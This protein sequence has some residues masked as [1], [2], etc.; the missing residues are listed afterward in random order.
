MIQW[1][2]H[3]YYPIPS[4]K[5]AEMMGA[6]KLMEFHATREESIYAEKTDPFHN[7]YE[8][9]HWKMADE[10]FS[11][12]DELV[13]LGG[14]RSGKSEFASKRVVKCTN[15]IPEANVLCMHTTSATSIEQQQ[16]YVYKYLPAEWKQAK[17]GK[18]T[19]MT[20]SKKGGFTESCCVTPNGSRIFFRNYSQNLDTGILEGSEWD[21]VW[22]DELCG[23]DHISALRFRLVTRANRPAPNYPNGYPWR[24]ML[25]TFTPVAGYTPTIREYLQGAKTEKWGMADPE[26]L[27]N[28]RVPIIQQPLR[29]NAKVI[30][31]HSVWN[32]FNDYRALKRTLQNDP[33]P[34]ILTRA[35]GLP[36]K[37]SGSMFPK[38]CTDHLVNDE[39]IPKD[40]TNYMVV[41]PS[42]GKNWV[43]IWVRVAKDGK[44]YVYR[45]FP[46]QVNPIEGVGMAGEWAVAGKKID[47]VKGH[48]QESWGWSLARYKEEILRQ[49]GNEK[50]FMRIMDSRFGSA[51]TPTKSG[52][53]TLIDEMAD[54]DMFFEPSVGV[55]IEEGITLVNSLLDFNSEQPISS[56]NC[57]KLYVHEDCKNLRFALSTWTNSDGKHA[58]T[59]DFCDLVRY[60]VLSAP[61]FLD[62]GSGTI[63]EGGGY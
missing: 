14:N 49:E 57:P 10:E 60:F 39:Q 29:D 7:G 48:A 55:R 42:H 20:F 34:K 59:K 28:E 6:E 3:P 52:I 43:M 56:M 63:F 36:T 2:D 26:L 62:E 1:T 51:P 45:E 40:G 44:C 9:D 27:E 15:D 38:F 61:V 54:M 46:D 47:G 58:A 23:V 30:Y 35:Y 24:G 4:R 37:V 18:V 33:R 5:E 41:D 25:I 22:L 50:I 16:Q 11:R 21:M 53:T 17:K 12:N 31:F 13:I 8:P 19:N 32:K